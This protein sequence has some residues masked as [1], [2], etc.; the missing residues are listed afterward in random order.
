MCCILIDTLYNLFKKI[1]AF[2]FKF[3]RTIDL[4][5]SGPGAF[6]LPKDLIAFLTLS[7]AMYHKNSTIPSPN[8]PG[9]TIPEP[10]QVLVVPD[11]EIPDGLGREFLVEFL[12]LPQG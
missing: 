8:L 2:S 3:L 9:P 6:L 12:Q 5:P 7:V 1:T 11:L 4:Y 10:V